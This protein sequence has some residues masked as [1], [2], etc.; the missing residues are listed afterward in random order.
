V[1]DEEGNPIP[2]MAVV[3][4]AKGA[5]VVRNVPKQV[6]E[7]AK[8]LA[9]LEKLQDSDIMGQS[10]AAADESSLGKARKMQRQKYVDRAKEI[11]DLRKKMASRSKV[12]RANQLHRAHPDWTKEQIL[13]AVNKESNA[14]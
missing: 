5:P 2:G 4:G 9:R 8:E 7:T 10:A 13:D 12:E 6:D 11:D 3:P 14:Q 1:L